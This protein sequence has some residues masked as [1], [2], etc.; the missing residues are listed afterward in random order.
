MICIGPSNCPPCHDPT[1]GRFAVSKEL[2]CFFRTHWLPGP[3]GNGN[4]M[5]E[6][7][8]KKKGEYKSKNP[9]INF[10]LWNSCKLL[11]TDFIMVHNCP[12]WDW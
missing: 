7:K 6:K 4:V 11:F 12:V 10:K 1:A 3:N 2:H 9:I 5:R 8:G